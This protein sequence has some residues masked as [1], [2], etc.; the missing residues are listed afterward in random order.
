MFCTPPATTRS[1]VPAHD[2]LRGEVDRLLRRAALPVDGDA[3]HLLG[4]PGGE[5]GGAGDVAGLRPDR[6]D[7][8]EDDVVDGGRV[9]A[10]PLDQGS[11]ACAP[12]SAGMGAGQPAAAPADRRADRVDDVGMR[13]W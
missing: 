5:P 2:R 7:A 6:V 12:R 1:A 10:R 13:H 11:G 8:A 3:G 4:Q 9:D